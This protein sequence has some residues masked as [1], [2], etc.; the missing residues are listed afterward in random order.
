MQTFC[1]RDIFVSQNRYIFLRKIRYDINFSCPVGH[2]ECVAHIEHLLCISKILTGF[3]SMIKVDNVNFYQASI[4]E[5]V[6]VVS[7]KTSSKTRT[8][9]SAVKIVTL[10]SVARLLI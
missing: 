5:M 2:I 7:S 8:V 9:S 10:F 6:I 4:V 1:L 3:I